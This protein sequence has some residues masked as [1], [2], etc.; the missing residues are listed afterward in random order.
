MLEIRPAHHCWIARK[1]CKKLKATYIHAGGKI[2]IIVEIN[3][4]TDFVARNSEFQDFAKEVAM[5]IAA[6][7]PKYVSKDN[8]PES[9][10]EDEKKI[11]LAQL[12]DLGKK[13][14]IVQKMLEGKLNKIVEESCLL[15][16]VYI[17][18][19]KLKI[20]DLL[21]E[22]VSKLGEN[23]KISRFVRYQIGETSSN[24]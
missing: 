12:H 15:N 18:D 8:M 10:I 23:V 16:Q 24:E 14:E 19:S 17:R 22:L 5:Q 1:L 7:D 20:E 3:C 9:F 4:E 21:N 2:G 6:S 11:I 13:P